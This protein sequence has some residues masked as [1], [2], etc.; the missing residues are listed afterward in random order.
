MLISV[1]T[2]QLYSLQ[3]DRRSEQFCVDSG[4]KDSETAAMQ[5]FITTDNQLI[6]PDP[7][8]AARPPC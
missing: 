2:G 5:V 7:G 4:I 8:T 1:E 6:R 3:R